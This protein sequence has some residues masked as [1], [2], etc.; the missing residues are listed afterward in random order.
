MPN[1]H[2]RES[3]VHID[4]TTTLEEPF[5]QASRLARYMSQNLDF[6]LALVG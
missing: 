5:V 4:T 1:T 2:V 3:P 6:C